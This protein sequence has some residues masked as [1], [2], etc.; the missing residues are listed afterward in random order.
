[1]G[2]R[3]GFAVPTGQDMSMWIL[4]WVQTLKGVPGYGEVCS[5]RLSCVSFREQGAPAACLRLQ[6]CWDESC[7]AEDSDRLRT[8]GP[9]DG[10]S[11]GGCWNA[12]LPWFMQSMTGGMCRRLCRRRGVMHPE[13]W[14]S[15]SDVAAAR[16]SW[17]LY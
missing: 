4:T 10:S 3:A 8:L 12:A 16:A 15:P 6:A 13:G 7:L 1:M 5:M 17:S 2:L 14:L 9:L 11:G